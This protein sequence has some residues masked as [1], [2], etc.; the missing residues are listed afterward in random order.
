MPDV[1]ADGGRRVLS[2]AADPTKW[3]LVQAIIML[4][5]LVLGTRVRLMACVPLLAEGSTTVLSLLGHLTQWLVVRAII[6]LRNQVTS[7]TRV[8]LGV[9]IAILVLFLVSQRHLDQ[10]LAVAHSVVY[11]LANNDWWSFL[12]LVL[13]PMTVV[14]S[15]VLAHLRR[16]QPRGRVELDDPLIQEFLCV[17]MMEWSV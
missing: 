17:Q 6:I 7:I 10:V 4:R 15:V 3:L 1:V 11:H 5:M 8:K 12:P 2:L 13:L 9:Y 16:G 14:V